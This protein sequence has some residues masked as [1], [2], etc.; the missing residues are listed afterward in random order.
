MNIG[1]SA[2]LVTALAA[3]VKK[4]KKNVNKKVSF[5]F[6]V[7]KYLLLYPTTACYQNFI[8][9][10]QLSAMRCA[11]FLVIWMMPG[12]LGIEKLVAFM[13]PSLKR[14]RLVN[15]IKSIVSLK[16]KLCGVI[17]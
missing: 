12:C 13:I 4:A 5:S 6:I 10:F 2:C 15:V 9:I 7:N 1:L 14:P 16:P 8:S 17:R 3:G 11:S